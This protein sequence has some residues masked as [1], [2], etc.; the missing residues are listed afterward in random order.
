VVLLRTTWN[1]AI[2]STR[3]ESSIGESLLAS[4]EISVLKRNSHEIGG[5]QRQ[6]L[7]LQRQAQPSPG[8]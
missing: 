3:P 5:L 4:H 1:A 8:Y 2:V 7:Q 6:R